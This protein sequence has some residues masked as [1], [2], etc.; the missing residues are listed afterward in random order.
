[1]ERGRLLLLLRLEAREI[2]IPLVQTIRRK[3]TSMRVQVCN[4]ASEQG[5]IIAEKNE[6][7]L[8]DSA[9]YHF[10][11]LRFFFF[12]GLLFVKLKRKRGHM[13]LLIA[14]APLPCVYS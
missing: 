12:F 6:K 4:F 5:K 1:M 14:D 10:T 11:V 3:I 7:S 8:S 2:V 9:T 13:N